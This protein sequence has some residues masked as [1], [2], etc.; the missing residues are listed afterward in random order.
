MITRDQILQMENLFSEYTIKRVHADAAHATFRNE[1]E[2]I[3]DLLQKGETTG[4]KILD[5]ALSGEYP[6]QDR[7]QSARKIYNHLKGHVGD[8]FFSLDK[9]S[10]CGFVPNRILRVGKIA[11][12]VFRLDGKNLCLEVEEGTLVQKLVYFYDNYSQ[13]KESVAGEKSGMVINK[14][15]VLVQSVQAHNSKDDDY[16]VLGAGQQT[17][18]SYLHQKKILPEATKECLEA[19]IMRTPLDGESDPDSYWTT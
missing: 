10:Y 3:R 9:D 16:C 1:H 11:A 12:P 19:L 8:Y 17:V 2:K 7:E 18:L 13:I 14:E 6:Y 5:W 4:D 15:I